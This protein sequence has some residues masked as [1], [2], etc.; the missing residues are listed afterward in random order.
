ML[1]TLDLEIPCHLA[2]HIGVK[3]VDVFLDRPRR[4][5]PDQPQLI[6]GRLAAAQV[7]VPERQPAVQAADRNLRPDLLQPDGLEHRRK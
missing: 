7:L 1:R 4:E 5:P 2:D 3:I 6:A